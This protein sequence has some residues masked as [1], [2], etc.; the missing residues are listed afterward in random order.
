METG[1]II[2]QKL[3]KVTKTN[4]LDDGIRLTFENGE[5][6]EFAH[7]RHE[8]YFIRGREDINPMKDILSEELARHWGIKRER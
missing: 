3:T 4:A 2:G 6:I 8:G 1:K 7:N 5:T